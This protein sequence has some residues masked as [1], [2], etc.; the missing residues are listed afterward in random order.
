M[1]Y[2]YQLTWDGILAAAEK[3]QTVNTLEGHII[4][5]KDRK[6]NTTDAYH[7]HMADIAGAL[8][9]GL[10]VPLPVELSFKLRKLEKQR[11]GW[12]TNA[13]SALPRNV[14]NRPFSWSHSALAQFTTCPQQYSAARFYFTTPFQETEHIRW[15][16][17]VHT[18]LEL[19]LKRKTPL[20]KEM[21]HMEQYCTAI[22]RAEKRSGGKLYVE[23]QLCIN[24]HFHPVDWFAPDAWGRIKIDVMLDC[25]DTVYIYDWK[26]GKKKEDRSQLLS[27]AA[28][29][30]LKFPEAKKFLFRYVWMQEA[31][32]ESALSGDTV[33]TQGVRFAWDD[34][35]ELILCATDAWRTEQFPCKPGGLCRGWC[36]VHVCEFNRPKNS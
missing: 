1:I 7:L 33:T 35:L 10:P 16:N 4:C 22:E 6:I 29:A 20:P 13:P 21:Q 23:E 32:K 12:G 34:L 17:R 25:G 18:A 14:K 9:Q 28:F 15:G 27:S 8:A 19:R 11:F 26:T 5:S 31:E 24:M 30:A 2:A 3:K 36:P